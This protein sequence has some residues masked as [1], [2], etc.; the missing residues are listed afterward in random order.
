VRIIVF[1]KQVMDPEVP[2]A[3]FRVD[4]AA[5]RVVPPQG[6]PPVVNGFDEQ[7]VEAALRIKAANSATVTVITVGAGLA[8]EVIKKPISMGADELFIVQDDGWQDRDA[9]GVARLLAAA[10]KK[11][12]EFDLILAGRQA[13]DTD[14]GQV[15]VGVAEELGLPAIT[16]ARKVE[17]ADGKVRVE[18]VL[19][20]GTEVVEAPLPAL[21]TVSNELGEARYPTLRGIMRAGRVQ[22]TVWTVADL[23]V[24]GIAQARVRL[25][26][27]YVPRVE[28]SCEFIEGENPAD[29]GKKLALK[30]REAKLL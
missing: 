13:S 11:A 1:A 20:D 26:R 30:L 12:G 22:P 9:F 21:V 18:R 2:P 3:K 7:A 6:V 14:R 8:P 23:G 10:V 27:L 5:N 4:E 19:V 17:V 16:I 29:T 24:D 25:R 15:A 28:K